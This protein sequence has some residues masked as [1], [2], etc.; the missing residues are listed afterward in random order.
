MAQPQG[1]TKGLVTEL[2]RTRTKR[3]QR[4][5]GAGTVESHTTSW[6]AGTGAWP[7]LELGRLGTAQ[8]KLSLEH[9]LCQKHS[10]AGA[11]QGDRYPPSLLSP[12]D[13]LVVLP[14]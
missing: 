13:L 9:S 8:H 6:P 3:G 12:S 4:R 2:G 14:A 1:F 10:K 5:Q 11:S 7:E